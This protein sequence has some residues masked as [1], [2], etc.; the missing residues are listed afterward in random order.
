VTTQC[1]FTQEELGHIVQLNGRLQY[2]RRAI[3]ARRREGKPFEYEESQAN[4][5]VWALEKV[6]ASTATQGEP[7]HRSFGEGLVDARRAD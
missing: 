6:G 5:I 3:G 4:A 1:T 2:L 7:L